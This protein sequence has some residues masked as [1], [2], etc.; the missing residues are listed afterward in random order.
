MFVQT[1]CTHDNLRRDR[2]IILSAPCNQFECIMW[3]LITIYTGVNM[4]MSVRTQC[5]LAENSYNILINISYFISINTYVPCTQS[6]LFFPQK[7]RDRHFCRPWSP[8]LSTVIIFVYI[9]HRGTHVWY[10]WKLL[11]YPGVLLIILGFCIS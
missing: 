11:I 8:F 3:P 4:S 2:V 7:F 5:V 10:Q 6:S 9:W 1:M